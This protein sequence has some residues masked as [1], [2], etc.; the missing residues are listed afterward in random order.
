MPD[1]QQKLGVDS[2]GVSPLARAGVKNKVSMDEY[3]GGGKVGS[4]IKNLQFSLKRHGVQG[5]CRDC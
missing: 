2:S 1:D 5:L 4:R 3:M